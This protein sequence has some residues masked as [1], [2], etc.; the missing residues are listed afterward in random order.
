M[1]ESRSSA[2]GR[3]RVHFA[4]RCTAGDTTEHHLSGML[5]AT[6]PSQHVAGRKD[7]CGAIAVIVIFAVVIVFGGRRSHDSSQRGALPRLLLLFLL[8]LLL[9]LALVILIA[10]A[11]SSSSSV[12][13]T[14]GITATFTFFSSSSFSRPSSSSPCAVCHHQH[15]SPSTAQSGSQ[16]V[17][18]LQAEAGGCEDS[19]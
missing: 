17:D 3:Q 12:A 4:A 15:R 9:S 16:A 14:I 19:V 8:L 18:H 11:V 1:E 10:T 7:A 6:H 2:P 5:E 13:S